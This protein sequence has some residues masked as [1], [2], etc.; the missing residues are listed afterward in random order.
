MFKH[1]STFAHIAFGLA[2]MALAAGCGS[3]GSSGPSAT[4]TGVSAAVTPTTGTSFTYTGT[5]TATG[6]T[7]ITYRWERSDGTLDAVQ[8]VQLAAAGSL[9]VTST[10]AAGFCIGNSNQAM[11]VRL[12]VLTP[13]VIESPKTNFTRTCVSIPT[14]PFP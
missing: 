3:D 1:L 8:S 10:W 13:N 6:A 5:I 14:I 12:N 2:V 7:A 11:W 9:S 4:V